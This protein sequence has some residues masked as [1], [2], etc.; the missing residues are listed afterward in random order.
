M[1]R[2]IVTWASAARLVVPLTCLMCLSPLTC[3]AADT[4]SPWTTFEGSI[5]LSLLVCYPFGSG[6]PAV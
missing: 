1:E 3:L 4:C 2:W 5:S 6:S